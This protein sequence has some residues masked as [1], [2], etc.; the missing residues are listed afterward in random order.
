MSISYGYIP[1]WQQR[2]DPWR[3]KQA[4]PVKTPAGLLATRAVQTKAGWVGQ[5]IVDKEVIWESKPFRT[6]KESQKTA[7]AAASERVLGALRKLL[8]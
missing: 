6:D 7:T 1:E 5:I 8:A 4:S 3:P 2:L